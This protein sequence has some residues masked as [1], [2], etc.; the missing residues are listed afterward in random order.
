MSIIQFL[1]VNLF[2]FYHCKILNGKNA[3]EEINFIIL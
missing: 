2:L 1:I 3:I